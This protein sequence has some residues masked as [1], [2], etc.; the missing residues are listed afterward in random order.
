[1]H[2]TARTALLSIGL[3]C[4]PLLALASPQG[5]ISP[6]PTAAILQLRSQTACATGFLL[7]DGLVV[8]NAHVANS[9]CPLGD[10]RQLAVLR[11]DA[12]GSEPRPIDV[13]TVS[14][15][16]TYPALDI[17]LLHL[18]LPPHFPSPFTL[19]A[20]PAALGGSVT[21]LGF[22]NCAALERSVGQI[23]ESDPIGFRTS[24]PVSHGSSGSPIIDDRFQV[25]GIVSEV[26]G[27]LPAIGSLVFGWRADAR[28]IR[29]EHL[30]ALRQTRSPAAALALEAR[31][32]N[33]FAS[34]LWPLSAPSRLLRSFH[35]FSS[36]EG[37]AASAT[38]SEPT[39][40]RLLFSSTQSFDSWSALTGIDWADPELK[41]LDQTALVQLC[42]E[43]GLQ[44]RPS[45]PLSLEA[46]Q[47]ALLRS[48]R[49]ADHVETL[50][51]LAASCSQGGYPG[52]ALTGITYAVGA[53]GTLLFISLLWG[54]SVGYLYARLQGG[55]KRRV[56]LCALAALTWPVSVIAWF[57]TRRTPAPPPPAKISARR[58][59]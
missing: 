40:A 57:V 28:A 43:H 39:A 31:L 59:A 38:L 58:R 2:H 30:E 53:L 4:I 48:G 41:T 21:T 24:A 32:V 29:A 27:V 12:V 18:E 49:P 51:S 13:G 11:A 7:D 37:L 25:V 26:T 36:L 35:L 50:I 23:I 22:P 33:E 42:E 54:T 56:A 5:S 15:E 14:I 55:R 6:D 10:C 9:V 1:M 20:P 44:S 16:Q 45:V 34:T 47:S 3:S 46:L 19:R 52:A 17:A 8:T